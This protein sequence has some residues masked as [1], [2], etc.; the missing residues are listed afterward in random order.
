VGAERGQQGHVLG[1]LVGDQL[2]PGGTDHD[3]RLGT[4]GDR[5]DHAIPIGRRST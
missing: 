1:A 2:L 5:G 4:T 3:I